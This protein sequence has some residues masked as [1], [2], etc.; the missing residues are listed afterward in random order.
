MATALT[1]NEVNRWE[2]N[3]PVAKEL[4]LGT[5][6]N[7]VISELNTASTANTTQ[8]GYWSALGIAGKKILAGTASFNAADLTDTIDSS[9]IGTVDAILITPQTDEAAYSAA[10]SGGTTTVTRP[11]SGTSGATY[12]YLIIGDPA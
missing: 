2:G 7:T 8:A 10:E 1:D 11:G 4:S 5:L 9:A 6:L 3:D 12:S